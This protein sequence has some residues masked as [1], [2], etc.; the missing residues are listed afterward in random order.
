MFLQHTHTHSHSLFLS[1]SHTHTR[2][3]AHTH[4]L[5]LS[6][7]Y[8]HT[9]I[10]TRARTHARTHAHTHT[11]THTHDK[12]QTRK[13]ITRSL[14]FRD[15]HNNNNHRLQRHHLHIWQQNKTKETGIFPHVP[16]KAHNSLCRTYATTE[17]FVGTAVIVI[18]TSSLLVFST[19]PAI[20]PSPPAHTPKGRKS[21]TIYTKH[22]L[23][24]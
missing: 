11:H 15:S 22:G 7:S 21:M 4:S 6:L 13:F 17:V 8:T 3:H 2:T 16:E 1:L 5:F 12:Q 9:H 24:E 14:Y 18:V 19:A 20:A 10:H 23:Y